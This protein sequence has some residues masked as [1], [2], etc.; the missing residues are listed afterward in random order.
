MTDEFELTLHGSTRCMD[1]LEQMA[2]SSK[3]VYKFTEL[4]TGNH[5][6]L[7]RKDSFWIVHG[8][9]NLMSWWNENRPSQNTHLAEF[10]PPEIEG[11]HYLSSLNHALCVFPYIHQFLLSACLC[12]S[13]SSSSSMLIRWRE[14][15]NHEKMKQK[16]NIW[17]TSL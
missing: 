7:D 14:T 16:E 15:E 1:N 4:T 12:A 17:V 10:L 2:P 9:D 5:M 6:R 13:S 11:A 8:Q 3:Y